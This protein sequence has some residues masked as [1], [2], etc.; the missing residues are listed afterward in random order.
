MRIATLASAS[1]SAFRARRSPTASTPP[2]LRTATASK[3]AN[4]LASC[5]AGFDVASKS[6]TTS[7][8]KKNTKP[9]MAPTKIELK[10][11]KGTRDWGGEGIILREHIF[12]TSKH[13]FS[14]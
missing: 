6:F 10:T 12:D 4:P 8:P 9:N 2:F 13:F 7:A 11:A 5:N 1:R 14:H 3:L